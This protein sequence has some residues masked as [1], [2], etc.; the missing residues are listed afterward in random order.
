M[1][2]SRPRDRFSFMKEIPISMRRNRKVAMLTVFH[3]IEWRLSKWQSS[4]SPVTIKQW[5]N[6]CM[7]F[8]QYQYLHWMKKR[9]LKLLTNECRLCSLMQIWWRHRRQLLIGWNIC[10][11]TATG[12]AYKAGIS[13][14]FTTK[15]SISSC[16]SKPSGV[17]LRQEN[18]P[19]T[20]Q[21]MTYRPF[22]AK[23]LSETRPA[24]Y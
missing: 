2:I 15:S 1:K 12:W 13:G 9:K 14:M 4:T 24:Y 11:V 21:I 10:H 17:H 18:M 6:L 8:V 22:K 3:E 19:S 5:D 20:I 23:S 7:E 16:L